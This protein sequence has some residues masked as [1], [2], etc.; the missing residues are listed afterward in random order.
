MTCSE[1]LLSNKSRVPFR[2]CRNLSE[3][4]LVSTC[5][6]CGFIYVAISIC[7]EGFDVRPLLSPSQTLTEQ[8]SRPPLLILVASGSAP[9]P[10]MP[11]QLGPTATQITVVTPLM[12]TAICSPALYRRGIKSD[13]FRAA[14]DHHDAEGGR[15]RRRG[16][17]QMGLRRPVRDPH[18]RVRLQLP[19]QRAH[20]LPFRAEVRE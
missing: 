9:Y 3:L 14:A 16:A 2:S 20:W 10:F 1:V 8:L 7:Y 6:V 4:T 13:M 17:V 18:H 19:R 12:Q 11:L 5:G 15:F